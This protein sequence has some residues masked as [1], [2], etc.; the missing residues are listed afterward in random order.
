MTLFWS[1]FIP[2]IRIDFSI[3]HLFSQK[4][5]MVDR[6]FS[7]RE[8]FGREDNVIT[9]I[10]KPIDHLD[11]NLFIELENLVYTI[12]ELPGVKS[13][14]SLFT[15]SDIDLN[16]W[17]G[18]LYDD[19]TPWNRDTILQTLRYIQDDPSIGARVL[20]KDLKYGLIMITLADIANN[21]RD[22][23]AL[24]NDIKTLTKKTSPEWIYSGVSVLRT[25]YVNYMLRDNFMFLPP[26]AILL[27]CILYFLFRN[28]VQVLLPILTVLITVVW[29]L[30]F[31]GLVGLEINI[32]TVSYTH[33]RA[34][35][36]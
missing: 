34:H 13:V 12:D 33:L 24:L 6:Y 28:W 10:Y 5:H 16:A 32:I 9:I 14:A 17:L 23:T 25:E 1:L 19:S 2:N 11:K 8:T 26:I 29:L 30:G 18:D 4:D 3:E 21:H 27:I 7:F 20:S 31:M 22:R 15:L 35:E 36:T